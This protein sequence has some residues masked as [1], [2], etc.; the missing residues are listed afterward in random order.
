VEFVLER[1][2]DQAVQDVREKVSAIRNKL[3]D[4]I[5][6]PKIA[7]VDPDSTPILFM[8]LSGEKSVRDLS[9]YADEVLK[10]QLQRINEVGDVTLNGLRLRQVRIW[11]DAAKMRAYE[12]SPTDVVLALKREMSNCPVVA[13]KLK[14]RIYCPD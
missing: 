10:E 1:N 7:K 13:L 12:V 3:P 6:E 8:N 2:I 9:T 14:P 11:L 5:E 4:D